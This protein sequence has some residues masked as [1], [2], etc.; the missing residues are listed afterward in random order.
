MEG[1]SCEGE[2]GTIT[3]QGHGEKGVS[4]WMV[5]KNKNKC[6]SERNKKGGPILALQ[7]DEE[8]KK[9]Q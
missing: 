3:K 6:D 1:G 8:E 2:G 9:E 7:E 4:E 5:R